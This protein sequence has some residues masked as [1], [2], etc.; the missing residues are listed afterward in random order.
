MVLASDVSLETGEESSAGLQFFSNALAIERS[1]R[2]VS[3]NSKRF[4]NSGQFFQTPLKCATALCERYR[5]FL[6]HYSDRFI[7]QNLSNERILIS[8]LTIRQL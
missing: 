6:W 2:K 3:S 4:S 7:V 1:R 5:Q 8:D